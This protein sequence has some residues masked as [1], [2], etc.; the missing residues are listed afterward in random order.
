MQP[1][2]RSTRKNA[3][4]QCGP[5]WSVLFQSPTQK[6]NCLLGC[7]IFCKDWATEYFEMINKMI[8][9]RKRKN[10]FISF[11]KLDEPK[12]KYFLVVFVVEN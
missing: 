6:S 2:G 1:T 3:F 11:I 9:K 8:E 5:S 4:A 7:D 12:E 10:I